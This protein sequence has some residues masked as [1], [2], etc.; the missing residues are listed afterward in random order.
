[1]PRDLFGECFLLNLPELKPR[2]EKESTHFNSCRFFTANLR[3]KDETLSLCQ[4][5]KKF[6]LPSINET[7]GPTV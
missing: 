3:F 2:A 6:V 4:K 7:P 5:G 1:M